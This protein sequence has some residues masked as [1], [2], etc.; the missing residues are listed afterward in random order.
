MKKV[1]VLV[2][3][4]AL[5]AMAMSVNAQTPNVQVYF[6]ENGSVTA[7][8]CPG[9][10][11]GTNTVLT[12]IANNF[13]MFLTAIEYQ[14]DYGPA[15]VFLGDQTNTPLVLGNSPSGISIAWALPQN[16]FDA[17]VTQQANVLWN[18]NDCSNMN[19][20]VR[21]QPHPV[22]GHVRATRWPDNVLVD[23]VGLTSLVC[24]TVPVTETTWGKV[25][26]L[27]SK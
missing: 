3:A 7:T 17:F 23:G 4:I 21:V 25:K 27:Y 24:A 14:I 8:D 1:L 15:F 12:V 16:A 9:G 10:G 2:S 11:M 18:C 19:A 26:S 6:D 13:G 20:P 5:M 22:S